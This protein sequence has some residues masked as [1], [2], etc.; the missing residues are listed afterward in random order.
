MVVWLAMAEFTSS[1]WNWLTAVKLGGQVQVAGT[2]SLMNVVSTTWLPK[3][4]LGEVTSGN[5]RAAV[6]DGNQPISF[7]PMVRLCVLV[8]YH[9]ANSSACCGCFVPAMTEM[10]EP[11]HRPELLAPAVHCGIPATAHLP[12]ES[13]AS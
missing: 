10:A 7:T 9:C 11:P 12:E 6:F 3:K 4:A 2:V 8:R 13:F 1:P 5:W